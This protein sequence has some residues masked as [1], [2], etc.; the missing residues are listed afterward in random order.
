VHARGVAN[1]PAPPELAAAFRAE[2]RKALERIG[3]RPLA[4]LP[5]LAAWRRAFGAFGVEPTRYR[6]AAEALLRRLTKHGGLPSVSLLV[7]LGNLVSISFAL[8]VAVLDLDGVV[9]AIAV[10]GAHGDERFTDLGASGVEQPSAGEVIFVD[11]A[12]V[13][14]ARRWCWRQSAQSA[15]T[16]ETTEILITVEGHHEQAPEDVRAAVRDLEELLSSFAHAA[17]PTSK[18]LG[19]GEPVFR[20]CANE[21][22]DAPELRPR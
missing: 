8:P 15:T 2:Q 11:D 7:D 5:S 1:G 9:G 22:L 10:R 18:L 14:H 3:E 12:Q 20:T 19:A 17:T 13:V 6:S 16:A 4:E 21:P